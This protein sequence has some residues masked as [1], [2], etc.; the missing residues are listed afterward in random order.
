[1][2]AF[3]FTNSFC[4]KAKSKPRYIRNCDCVRR[5]GIVA[6][7]FSTARMLETIGRRQSVSRLPQYEVILCSV[8]AYLKKTPGPMSSRVDRDR[9]DSK[10]H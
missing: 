8:P 3:V 10:Q 2:T 9:H 6:N 5:V 4:L 7:S 1:M